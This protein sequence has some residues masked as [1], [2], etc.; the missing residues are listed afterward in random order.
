MSV[1]GTEQFLCSVCSV[2]SVPFLD[3]SAA[4]ENGVCSAAAVSRSK[5]LSGNRLTNAGSR[6]SARHSRAAPAMSAS[7]T[8]RGFTGGRPATDWPRVGVTATCAPSGVLGGDE[9]SPQKTKRAS[10]SDF[11]FAG[12]GTSSSSSTSSAVAKSTP[13]H[14]PPRTAFPTLPE[15]SVSVGSRPGFAASH[16][17][18][19]THTKVH[20][21]SPAA[22]LWS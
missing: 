5:C 6:Q 20:D 9:A 19:A 10:S 21:P 17:A 22:P 14:P 13:E 2:S 1:E 8:N 12:V 18:S 16:S 3:A 4:T 15:T 11:C 7:R